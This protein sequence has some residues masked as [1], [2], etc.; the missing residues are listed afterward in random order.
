MHDEFTRLMMGL[1]LP[2]G[3]YETGVA[4]AVSG[5]ADSTALALLL[6]DWC[7]E[8]GFPLLA[9]TCDHGL[10]RESA[11]EARDVAD[12]LR[13]C[14]VE[15]VVLSLRV[16]PGTAIQERARDARYAAMSSV[17][18]RRGMS[19]LALGH[20][21]MDQ[22]ETVAHRLASGSRDPLALAGMLPVRAMQEILLLRPLLECGKGA[23]KD[24]LREERMPW[25]EDP[26]NANEGFARV[27][28]R[29]ALRNDPAEV[30]RLLDIAR[31]GLCLRRETDTRATEIRGE[32][33]LRTLPW[34]A[35]L[36]DV[37]R[38]PRDVA[39]AEVVRNLLYAA[40]G[41]HPSASS[42][43][44]L[45]M[46]EGNR[47]L[48]GAETRFVAGSGTWFSR[49]LAAMSKD[50][51]PARAFAGWDGRIRLADVEVPGGFLGVLG[52]A[53]A[54]WARK[55]ASIDVP[56]RVLTSVPCL[57]D[58]H[59]VGLAIPHLG[60]GP[61]LPLLPTRRERPLVASA[62]VVNNVR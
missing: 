43:R 28:I 52:E 39:G 11:A 27:R 45:A 24:F 23:L 10:R 26:S 35:S 38:I 8:R 48:G 12:R 49:E 29:N 3:E 61:S 2:A 9:L 36:V 44:L 13:D 25:V 54:T 5:G 6:R 56:H 47:T 1:G 59:G 42:E 14:G 18:R 62:L 33:V 22:A 40:S 34:G 17:V 60:Y 15:T 41:H 30:D 51:V 46:L 16:Q 19:L 4:V 20:H 7:A 57:R 53:G 31:E 55:A 32:A 50:G 58:A 37:A 21:A